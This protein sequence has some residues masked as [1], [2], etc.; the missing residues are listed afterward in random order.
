MIVHIVILDM[1]FDKTINN[2]MGNVVVKTSA[3]KQHVAEIERGIWTV[4]EREIRIITTIIFKY[5]QKITM[6][7]IVYI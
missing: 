7:K 3:S 2:L 5:P 6:T 1:E 4:K